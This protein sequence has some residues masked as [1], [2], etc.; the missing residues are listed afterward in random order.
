MRRPPP[1]VQDLAL[2]VVLA[3]IQLALLPEVAHWAVLAPLLVLEPV[4][5]VA[6]ESTGNVDRLSAALVVVVAWWI[7]TTLRERRSYALELERQAEALRA[8][9]H[10][11]AV[12]A[13]AAERLRLARELHDVVA[14]SLAMVAPHS[15]VGAHNAQQR[16]ED[17]VRALEAVNKGDPGRTGRAGGAADRPSG[18]L[19]C[20]RGRPATAD[21]D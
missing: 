21:S 14:H 5:L 8:A 16:P 1:L 18:R 10:E 3:I 4:V 13:V 12:Q 2:V 9:R 7:G 17:A 6:R 15:S 19:H 20:G 11:L